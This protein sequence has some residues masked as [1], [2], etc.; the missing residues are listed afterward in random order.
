MNSQNC[1]TLKNESGPGETIFRSITHQG[2]TITPTG[3]AYLGFH[4]GMRAIILIVEESR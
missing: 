3:E 1:N 2:I 4:N